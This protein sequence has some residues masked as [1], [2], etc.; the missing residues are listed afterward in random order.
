MR[1]IDRNAPNGD[2]ALVVEARARLNSFDF[3]P[4]LDDGEEL[5]GIRFRADFFVAE[6][7]DEPLDEAPLPNRTLLHPVRRDSS[8]QRFRP[9]ATRSPASN[10]ALHSRME[11]LRSCA[12]SMNRPS[13]STNLYWF[14]LRSSSVFQACGSPC[15]R[16]ESAGSKASRLASA[17]C[18]A[19]SMTFSEQGR[20]SLGQAVEM[21]DE[22]SEAFSAPVG[23]LTPGGIGIQACCNVRQMT[24]IWSSIGRPS[25]AS[26]GPSRSSSI[27]PLFVSWRSTRTYPRPL[28]V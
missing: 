6:A 23:Y 4:R 15:A 5:F 27:A 12:R 24:L 14:V 2:I 11:M 8:A 10:S 18:N 28:A 1:C 13:G 3:S 7:I 17:N 19:I 20:P 25:M 9:E 26:C 22:I 16:T 21:Y